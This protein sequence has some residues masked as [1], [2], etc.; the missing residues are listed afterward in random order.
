MIAAKGTPTELKNVY[1]KDSLR[2]KPKDKAKLGSYLNESDIEY[3]IKNDLYII[4]LE[5]TLA[6]IPIL[7]NTKDNLESIQVFNG[8]MDDA[9]IEITG[10]EIREWF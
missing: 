7:E 1:S 2:I 8:S 6:S 4:R 10:K 3:K 9:F 5:N